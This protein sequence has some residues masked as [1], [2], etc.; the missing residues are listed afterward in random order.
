MASTNSGQVAPS[1][2]L[3]LNLSGAVAPSPFQTAMP[4]PGILAPSP[5]HQQVLAALQMDVSGSFAKSSL[6]SDVMGSANLSN[7]GV[8]TPH[9]TGSFTSMRSAHATQITRMASAL[10][11]PTGASASGSVMYG[12]NPGVA[13]GAVLTGS[14]VGRQSYG[15]GAAS[16][17][18]QAASSGRP[19]LEGSASPSQTNNSHSQGSRGQAALAGMGWG[20]GG[21]APAAAAVGPRRTG[22]RKPACE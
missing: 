2:T 17:L 7:M 4:P 12:S 10:I 5:Y 18:A 20:S 19:S 16:P 11:L 8:R 22:P 13:Y 3:N 1:H 9:A 21:G 15:L 6:A 14:N